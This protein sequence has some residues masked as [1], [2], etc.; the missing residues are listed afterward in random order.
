MV[1]FLWDW[2]RSCWCFLGIFDSCSKRF[3]WEL[4]ELLFGYDYKYIYFNIGYNLKVI[5]M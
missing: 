2:G 5:D 3:N 1:F 4:G